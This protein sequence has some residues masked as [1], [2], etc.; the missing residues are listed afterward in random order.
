MTKIE[1]RLRTDLPS[2]ADALLDSERRGK[3]SG[4]GGDA[5][6]SPPSVTSSTTGSR[7][8]PTWVLLGAGAVVVVIV[9]ALALWREGDSATTVG[10]ADRPA[11]PDG[12]GSWTVIP[13]APVPAPAF[14]VAAWTG[15]DAVFWAGSNLDRSYAY[16]EAVAFDPVSQTWRDVDEPGWGHPGV[17]GAAFDGELFVVAKGGGSRFDFDTGEWVDLPQVEDM[18]FSAIVATDTAIWGLGPS[19]DSLEGQP[20]VAI[21]QYDP[22]QDAWVHGPAFEGTD[23]TAETVDAVRDIDRPVVWTGSDIVVWGGR[24]GIAFRPSERT[25]TEVPEL[26]HPAAQVVDSRAVAGADGLTVVA[27]LRDGADTATGIARFNAGQWSWSVG[28]L[29]RV[30]LSAATVAA[31]DSWIVLLPAEATPITVH[32]PSGAWEQHPDAPIGG[33]QAP[34]AVWSGEQL[35]VWGGVPH[36]GSSEDPGTGAAW[37]PPARG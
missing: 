13:E 37:T 1:D 36:E 6:A 23:A 9:A 29:P 7:G 17:V 21:V 11:T 25:W 19:L 10:T 33:V 8:R 4:V 12:F 31:A 14:P 32:V 24:A 18:F 28:D 34:G 20:D 15:S 27:E 3:A 22:D 2:L 16:T 35:I 30:D 26:Q 5:A